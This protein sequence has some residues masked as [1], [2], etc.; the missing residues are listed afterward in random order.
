MDNYLLGCLVC[1]GLIV[2]KDKI[3]NLKIIALIAFISYPLYIIHHPIIYQCGLP[4]VPLM[5]VAAF[6]ISFFIEHPIVRWSKKKF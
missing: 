1:I 6:L 3:P 4:G 2:I 5:I